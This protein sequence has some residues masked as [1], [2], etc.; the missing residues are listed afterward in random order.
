M[1]LFAHLPGNVRFVAYN[2]RSYAGSAATV[3]PHKEGGT[4]ATAA[5][6]GDLLGFID[7]MT[8]TLGVPGVGADGKGGVALLVSPLAFRLRH[9]FR[10]LL[11]GGSEARNPAGLDCAD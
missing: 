4:D 7:F 11:A 10:Q 9:S 6:L 1:P 3:A 8:E 5:Y 2:Q